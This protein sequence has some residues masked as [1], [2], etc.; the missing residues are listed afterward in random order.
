MKKNDNYFPE[1][2]IF[3]G[4][5]ATCDAGFPVTSQQGRLI[6]AIAEGEKIEDF[7]NSLMVL[8]LFDTE[9]L[10]E[11]A[12]L[13]FILD[14]IKS[15][16][17]EDN[18]FNRRCYNQGQLDI[19]KEL[20]ENV[21]EE[22]ITN[23]LVKLRNDYDISALKEI[24]KICPQD[25]TTVVMDTFN[26]ID[27]HYLNNEGFYGKDGI[28]LSGYRL[29]GARNALVMIIQ[30]VMTSV[31]QKTI[32]HNQKIHAK[33]LSFAQDLV[34]Y[35]FKDTKNKD[36]IDFR[37]R[38]FFILPFYFI[39]L[40]WDHYLLWQIFQANKDFNDN[41]LG[42]GNIN[43]KLKFFNDLAIR[44]GLRELSRTSTSEINNKI[45]YPYNETVV[46]RVNDSDYGNNRIVRIGKYFFPHGSLALRAC[47]SCGGL[48]GSFG[49]TW[50]LNSNSLFPPALIP[51][52][53]KIVSRTDRE[54][55]HVQKGYYDV[56]ECIH[57]GAIT[58]VKD[59]L[60]IMQTIMKGNYHPSLKMI[61]AEI[62]SYLMHSNHIIFMGYSLPKDDL[63]WK[64]I[65]L[66]RKSRGEKLKISV[67]VGYQ[68]VKKWQY[69]KRLDQLNEVGND[70]YKTFFDIFDGCEMRFFTGGIPAVFDVYSV[71]EI[72]EYK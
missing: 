45:W 21:A 17:N 62:N 47:P 44:L 35:A 16:G 37:E 50:D 12:K 3:W 66:A 20:F 1:T 14:D 70:Q 25:P 10:D 2:A 67:I 54:K 6:L 72:L 24:I 26:L 13:L 33:Y 69:A 57:C 58:S 38:D 19:A 71:D 51:S 30:T 39:S 31:Y 61:Q 9:P 41:S 7:K 48:V 49:D 8:S 4:A 34:S 63:V 59:S 29:I 28:A 46:Q 11:F 43:K 55:E 65:L 22:D 18:N 40:N 53:R 36:G 60:M 32:K 5:G 27:Y 15:A 42:F 64:S 68:G 52:L 56:M 23:L